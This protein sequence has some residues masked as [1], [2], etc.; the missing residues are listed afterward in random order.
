[1]RR[2]VRQSILTSGE[3][4]NQNEEP[5][6]ELTPFPLPPQLYPQ[7]IAAGR[8]HIVITDGEDFSL[9]ATLE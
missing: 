3:S 6:S 2:S 1:M 8:K 7:A 9:N 5:S 4:L